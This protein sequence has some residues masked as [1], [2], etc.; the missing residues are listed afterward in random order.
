MDR[1]QVWQLALNIVGRAA[2]PLFLLLAG[3][4]LGPR[5]RATG[6]RAP[7]RSYVRHLAILYVAACLFYWIADLAKLARSRGLGAGLAAFVER[8]AADPLAPADARAPVRTSGS[9]SC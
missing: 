6:R 1:I 5:L 8:Q 3:E 4:H 9:S 2:V 7:R